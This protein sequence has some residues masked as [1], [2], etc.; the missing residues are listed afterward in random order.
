M[1]TVI[2]Q[3]TKDF[4]QAMKDGNTDAMVA[5]PK[6]LAEAERN[7]GLA[8]LIKAIEADEDL[9]KEHSATLKV[10]VAAHTIN[11]MMEESIKEEERTEPAVVAETVKEEAEEELPAA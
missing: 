1:T 8:D 5:L 4:I 6:T 7:D 2:E 9:A 11:N 10:L 3:H